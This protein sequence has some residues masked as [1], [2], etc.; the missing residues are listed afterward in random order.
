VPIDFDF[1]YYEKFAVLL[2]N[3]ISTGAFHSAIIEYPE[4]SRE[5]AFN[6]IGYREI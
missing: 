5:K 1:F 2:R 6:F 3:E 4:Q